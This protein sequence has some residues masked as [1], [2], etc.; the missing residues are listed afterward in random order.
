MANCDTSVITSSAASSVA[1]VLEDC[2]SSEKSNSSYDK[3]WSPDTAQKGIGLTEMLA[4][5]QGKMSALKDDIA[6]SVASLEKDNE[7]MMITLVSEEYIET[8]TEPIMSNPCNAYNKELMGHTEDFFRHMQ[9]YFDAINATWTSYL[10]KR[11]AYKAML[12]AYQILECEQE[13]LHTQM[14]KAGYDVRNKLKDMHGL[15]RDD[16]RG[17]T[18]VSKVMKEKET[19]RSKKPRYT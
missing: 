12:E 16:K 19:Q 15:L 3:G 4:G 13:A 2:K 8:Q 5:V 11:T 9:H 7:S 18:T 14:T 6:D 1:R 17:Y 10:E